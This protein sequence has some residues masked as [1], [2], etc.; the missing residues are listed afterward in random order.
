MS[1]FLAIDFGLANVQNS[2][3]LSSNFT[4]TDNL[5]IVL[6]GLIKFVMG[7]SGVVVFCY[8]IWAGWLWM[9]AGGDDKQVAKAKT[10]MKNSVIGLAILMLSYALS[11]FAL[12]TIGKVMTG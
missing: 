7:I 11:S 3:E 8:I 6:G 2:T 5:Y 12:E 1:K 9:T 4:G 10:I